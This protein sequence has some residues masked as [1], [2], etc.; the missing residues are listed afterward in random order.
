MRSQA[1][2]NAYKPNVTTSVSESKDQTSLPTSKIY[3]NIDVWGQEPSP[4]PLLVRHG[5]LLSI[6]SSVT[7]LKCLLIRVAALRG[8]GMLTSIFILK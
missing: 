6:S 4:P 2:M 5:L 1:A 8:I 7:Y 3:H